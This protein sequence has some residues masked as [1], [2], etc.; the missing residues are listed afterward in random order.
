MRLSACLFLALCL[1][2]GMISAQDQPKFSPAQQEVLDA[3]NARLEAGK[4]RDGSWSQY[5]ADDC[6]FSDDDGNLTTKA[7]IIDHTKDWPP[8]YDQSMD[9]RDYVIHMYGETAVMNYRFTAHEQIGDSDIITEMRATETYVKQSGSWLLVARQ[10][11]PLPINFY[12]P[13]AVKTS[14]YKDYVGEY[15]W[16]PLDDVETISVKDGKLWF[17]LG[18][19]G[20]EYFPMGRETFFL[21]TELGSVTFVRDA[22]GHVTGYTYHLA[23]GQEIHAKKIK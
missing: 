21:K 9:F 8:E 2:A 4:R 17:Q 7:K 16:R 22:K 19:D 14:R 5:I 20:E 15:Q 13:V 18:D 10:W 3:R 12:K 11:G 1:P 6:I 23:D